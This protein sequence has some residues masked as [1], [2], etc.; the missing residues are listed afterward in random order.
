[1][2]WA[3]EQ[4]N[5]VESGQ[6]PLPMGIGLSDWVPMEGEEGDIFLGNPNELFAIGDTADGALSTTDTGEE[7]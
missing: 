1:M 7:R 2:K 6:K 3:Q 5:M 4:Q